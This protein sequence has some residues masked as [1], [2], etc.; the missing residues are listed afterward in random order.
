LLGQPHHQPGR[1]RHGLLYNQACVD[2][3]A[4]AAAG[5]CDDVT[6]PGSKNPHL[7]I[8]KV[9]N[10]GGFD[11][12]GDVISYTITVTNDGNVTLTNVAVTDAQVSDLDCDAGT[13]GNQ[14]SGFTLAP[15]AQLTCT[16]SHS[17]TQAD[18]DAG[19]FYNQACVDDGP[20]NAAGQC[21]AVTT[22]GEQNPELSITK[23]DDGETFS[24]VGDVIDYEIHAWNSG[25]VTLH[26]VVVT[27]EQA[28]DNLVCVPSLPV[29]DLAPGE[30]ID[31]TAS[32]TVTQADL[33]A[34]SYK[35]VACVDDTEGPA[36]EKCADVTTE[37]EE[38]PD[39]DIEKLATEQGFDEIG[40]VIHYT[41]TATNSG[42]VTLHDVL[43][44]DPNVSNLD[45]TPDN[46]MADLEP[47]DS[48]VCTASHTIDQSDL[49]AGSVFNEACVDDGQGPA[50]EACSDVTTEGEQNPALDILK[51][52][53][54]EEFTDVG[55]VLHYT[56]TATNIGNVTLHD[57]VV[58]G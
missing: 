23:V 31:C 33:D 52:V 9:D 42:N 11:S 49:D 28:D 55:Q 18:L 38:N 57:V 35:N 5:V 13:A 21:D 29:A 54:E 12:V 3:G 51:E 2:D 46:P 41:I 40:D 14:T 50:T 32:H 39:L 15:G 56:I 1:H 30:A 24:A 19:S 45:C 36:A 20:G 10:T 6:T 26:G 47:G 48:I 43:V 17:I 4:G 27:D 22:E 53:A 16:A 8:D 34:G 25:N 44:T 7:T 37:G 58:T